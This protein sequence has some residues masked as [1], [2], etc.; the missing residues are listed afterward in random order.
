M[1]DPL[2]QVSD[3]VQEH[4]PQA[5][6][7]VRSYDRAHSIE[8]RKRNI[9][10]EIRESVESAMILGTAALT[11]LGVE[12][13]RVDEVALDVCR[14]DELR[15]QMQVDGELQDG[16]D[17]LHV[18]TVTPEPLVMPKGYAKPLTKETGDVV[19][20]ADKEDSSAAE[21]V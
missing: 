17:T 12:D 9:D 11:E 14:R 8:L 4:A 21:S 10:F 19:G 16:R 18:N 3:L 5:K 13:E 15:L 1:S 6:V 20:N 7:Y 2:L